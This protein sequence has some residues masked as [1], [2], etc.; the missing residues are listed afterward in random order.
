MLLC[1]RLYK[2]VFIL[3]FWSL[4]LWAG[5]FLA[6]TEDVPLMRGMSYS[7]EETFSFDSEDGRLFFS[8][9]FID[10]KTQ[11]IK[12]FY[13]NTLPQ[14]GWKETQNGVFERDGDIL[15]IAVVDKEYHSQ[16]KATVIFELI[17]KS[18]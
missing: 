9:T 4:P 2:F 1:L 3:C 11:K 17:T 8:K 5:Q 15:K 16:K 10:E 13:V 6:G 7:Q 18:K 14:L 12:D